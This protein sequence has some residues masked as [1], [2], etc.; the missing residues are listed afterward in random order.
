MAISTF[1]S[2]GR[3]VDVI[4]A[5]HES[6]EKS[7]R[8]GTVYREGDAATPS[9]ASQSATFGGREKMSSVPTVRHASCC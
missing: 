3:A 4:R 7:E 9:A 2:G 1:C 5:G 8:S 6:R